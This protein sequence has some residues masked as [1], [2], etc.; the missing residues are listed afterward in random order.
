LGVPDLAYGWT[1]LTG[2][3]FGRLAAEQHNLAISIYRPFSGYG[4]DQDLAYPFPAIIERA[5]NHQDGD[6]EVWGSGRQVRDFVHIDDCVRCVLSTMDKL[7]A[8]TP[9]NISTGAATSFIEFASLTLEILGKEAR[10]RGKSDMP[11]GAEYRVGD[12][13]RQNDHE[14]FSAISLKEGIERALRERPG[15]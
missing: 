13:S 1:K 11:E 3:Y 10:V 2:E 4:T 7:D 15:F 12:T 14:F 5:I 6:F 9:L 8:K